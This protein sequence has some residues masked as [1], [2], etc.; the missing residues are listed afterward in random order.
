MAAITKSA[1]AIAILQIRPGELNPALANNDQKTI[2]VQAVSGH[3][4]LKS[5]IK[6]HLTPDLLKS[7]GIVKGIMLA[8]AG[9]CT[10]YDITV[11]ATHATKGQPSPKYKLPSYRVCVPELHFALPKPNKLVDPS[12]TDRIIIDSYPICQ[13]ISVDVAKKP[14]NPGDLIKISFSND[15]ETLKYHGPVDST[16]TQVPKTDKQQ[17]QTCIEKCKLSYS[18]PG[19]SGDNI[20]SKKKKTFK[21]QMPSTDKVGAANACKTKCAPNS[22]TSAPKPEKPPKENSDCE[23]NPLGLV[24]MYKWQHEVMKEKS[25]NVLVTRPDASWAS[26]RMKSY[27]EKVLNHPVWTDNTVWRIGQISAEAADG[28]KQLPD[29]PFHH[30]FGD[31][32]EVVL[33]TKGIK[34]TDSPAPRKNL[35]VIRLVTLLILSEQNG[36]KEILIRNRYIELLRK[37]RDLPNKEK[38]SS[39]PKSSKMA[40][41]MKSNI[42]NNKEYEKKIMSDSFLKNRVT[43][44]TTT[45]MQIK[46]YKSENMAKEQERIRKFLKNK[47]PGKY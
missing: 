31:D 13:A 1:P 37:W 26:L 9:G 25:K 29:F 8:P 24:D 39:I 36:V 3:G 19:T 27:I 42:L 2:D 17:A 46:M 11:A 4:I 21:N 45:K 7:V 12:D 32:I 33:P 38:Y 44:Y 16:R 22:K 47:C 40:A 15:L 14:V 28:I 43:G 18:N 20:S 41:I 35:D 10:P 5:I 6:A 23:K 34:V 30:R